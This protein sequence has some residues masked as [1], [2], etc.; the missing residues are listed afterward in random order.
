MSSLNIRMSY[1]VLSFAWRS[2]DHMDMDSGAMPFSLLAKATVQAV[3][4]F[5]CVMVWKMDWQ[6]LPAPSSANRRLITYGILPQL[7][8]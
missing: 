1:T 2:K 4:V 3:F 8:R 6:L 7:P 5:E